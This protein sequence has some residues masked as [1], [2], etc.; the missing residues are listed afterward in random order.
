MAF[1]DLTL[2]QASGNSTV[3]A[4]VLVRN[5]IDG[6]LAFQRTVPLPRRAGALRMPVYLPPSKVPLG[7][8]VLVQLAPG[9]IGN[10]FMV[11]DWF[12]NSGGARIGRD[13]AIAALRGGH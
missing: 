5:M 7:W 8:Q 10:S 1:L 11:G 6:T 2:Q 13:R 12:V 9:S 3:L 4:N